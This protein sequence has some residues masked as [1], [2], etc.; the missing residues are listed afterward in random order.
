MIMWVEKEG[1]ACTVY[2]RSV[3]SLQSAGKFLFAALAPKDGEALY[4]AWGL[5][6]ILEGHVWADFT[7]LGTGMLFIKHCLIPLGRPLD[8]L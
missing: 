5:P 1:I 2:A 6:P 3:R 8:D 4:F 7:N